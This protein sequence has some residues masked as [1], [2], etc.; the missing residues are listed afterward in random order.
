M[1]DVEEIESRIHAA[2]DSG[3]I[4][5]VNHKPINIYTPEGF[6]ILGNIIEGNADSLN[7]KY[8]GSFDHL[9]RHILGFGMKPIDKQHLVPSALELF[10]TSTRDPAFYRMWKKILNYFL[11]YKEHLPTYTHDDIVFPGVKIESVAVDKLLTYFEHFDSVISNGVIVSSQKDAESTI[12]KVRQH[13]LNHKPYTY[14]IT[15]N[16]DKNVKAMV[17]VFLGPKYDQHGHEMHL[18]D[19]WMNYVELDQWVV[20]CKY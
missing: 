7:I 6:N 12:I 18:V 20:D 8:Y 9:I 11:K 17:R 19:N 13:R 2:I 4:I 1:Q 5:D 14:H 16:S 15:V 10:T 3:Y